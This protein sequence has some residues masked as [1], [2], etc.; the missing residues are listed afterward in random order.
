MYSMVNWDRTLKIGIECVINV[1]NSKIKGNIKYE[2]IYIKYLRCLLLYICGGK[3]II[4]Y[5]YCNLYLVKNLM[6]DD[7]ILFLEYLKILKKEFY[8]VGFFLYD[9]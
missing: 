3:C 4:L 9:E 5:W 7:F 2:F 8:R 6:A 1:F